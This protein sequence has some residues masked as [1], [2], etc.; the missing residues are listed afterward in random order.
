MGNTRL[1]ALAGRSLVD[2]IPN[3]TDP[4]SPPPAALGPVLETWL[5]I[6]YIEPEQAIRGTGK[7]PK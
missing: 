1:V 2:R 4:I 6:G 5:R 3:E 7:C